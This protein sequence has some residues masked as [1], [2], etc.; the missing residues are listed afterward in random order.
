VIHTST[1]PGKTVSEE[2]ATADPPSSQ[3]CADAVDEQ[4]RYGESEIAGATVT[5]SRPGTFGTTYLYET[6]TAWIVCD[7]FAA[8][9][10]GAPTL[11][12]A[13]LKTDDYEPTQR[14]I[15]IS[16]NI[17]GLDPRSWK[18][19]YFAAGRDFD[20]VHAISYAFP[21]GH[22]ED[23]VVGQNGLWSMNYQPTSGPLANP[24]TNFTT[25]DP[26]R[27]TVSY[28]DAVGGGADEFTLRWGAGTCGQVN[29]GC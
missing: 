12:D 10:G 14:T 2:D 25:L 26:I 22:T 16:Q 3:S 5:A 20:G 28:T 9:D 6:K 19:Q 7:D 18:Y 17:V 4:S 8:G 21:D 15:G 29:H 1:A 13:H 23:A 11:L 24:D 27:V